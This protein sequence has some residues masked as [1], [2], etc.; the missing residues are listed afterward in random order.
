M[1]IQVRDVFNRVKSVFNL[2]GPKYVNPSNGLYG[3]MSGGWT[4]GQLEA[5]GSVGTLYS[6]INLLATSTAQVDW[7]LYRK[8]V[9]GRRVYGPAEDNRVEVTQHQALVVFKKPNDLMTRMELIERTQQHLDLAGESFWLIEKTDV[10]SIPVGI[11][12]IRPDRMIE[13]VSEQGLIGWVYKQPDGTRIP[14]KLDEIV[15]IKMPNPTNVYRGLSPIEAISIDLEAVHASAQYNRNYFRNSAAPSGVILAEGSLSDREFDRV[16][17]QWSER[18][19]GVRNAHRVG[20]LE[21]GLKW[22][23]TT[24]KLRD[25]QF[26]ELRNLSR[27]LIREAYGIHKHMLGLADDVN[28]ANAV[29]A[30]AD[31]AAWKTAPRL[32][33]IKQALN[34]VFLPMFGPTSS[35]VEFCYENPVPEDRE[36]E[37]AERD[38]KVSAAVALINAGGKPESVLEAVG[39]PPI[40]WE[41]KQPIQTPAIPAPVSPAPAPQPGEVDTD[42][43]LS[44]ADLADAMRLL[45]DVFQ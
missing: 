34:S 36:S 2:G 12:P 44:P 28:R 26:V 20:L 1:K 41:E 14:Y 32:E 29:A 19:K 11:W 6:I 16:V 25:M 40:E 33:R 30:G 35:N 39:L 8:S 10:G 27:E 13:V 9:D 22:V 24:T 45:K 21:N 4:A 17:M 43:T 23:D 42:V 5:M 37:N 31:F 18:H 7:H 38:S 15:H 3:L